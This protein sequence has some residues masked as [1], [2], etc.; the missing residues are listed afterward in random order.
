M[1]ILKVIHGYPMRYNAGSEVYSQL[2]C[3]ELAK[4]HQV[5]VF[6]RFEDP[7]LADYT[8]QQ[9]YDA[10]GNLIAII[11]PNGERQSID[12]DLAGQITQRSDATGAVIEKLSYTPLGQV[13]VQA[14]ALDKIKKLEEEIKQLKELLI[15]KDINGLMNEAY[16]E[17]AAKRLGFK[18]VEE[19]KKKLKL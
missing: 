17:Y 3:H 18:S 15:Q 4:K 2:L 13:A 11:S 8:M 14:D 9:E 12:Y 7:F 1:E 19:L 6:S 10:V 5:E 16:L